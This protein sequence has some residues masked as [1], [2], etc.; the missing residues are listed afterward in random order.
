MIWSGAPGIGASTAAQSEPSWSCAGSRA[1]A[2]STPAP[3]SPRAATTLATSA[4]TV[5]ITTGLSSAFLGRSSPTV[6]KSSPVSS[7]SEAASASPATERYRSATAPPMA[8][9]ATRRLFHQGGRRV[10][11][12]SSVP[13]T[14][15]MAAVRLRRRMI[16]PG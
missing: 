9:A 4:S 1:G 8:S 14:G 11:I 12:T 10:W 16:R 7:S 15:L 2:A 3:I 13:G 6:A 5:T